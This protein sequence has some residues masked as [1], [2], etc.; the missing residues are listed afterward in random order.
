MHARPSRTKSRAE[1]AFREAFERLKRGKK[2]IKV[3]QNNVAKEAGLVPSALKKARFPGL[4]EEIQRWIEEH[5]D[6][7]TR[8]GR[9]AT[10][11]QRNRNRDLRQKNESLCRQRDNALGLLA[12]AD[13]RI[14]ELT[15]ENSRLQASLPSS[16][17]LSMT[18][19]WRGPRPSPSE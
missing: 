6:K 11:A 1:I 12:E 10:L 3:T 8:S 5:G 4:V 13:A 19:S 9:Q 15:I 14:L 17:P 2:G 18:G 7:R 16:E